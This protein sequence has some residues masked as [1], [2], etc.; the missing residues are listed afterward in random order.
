MA[1]QPSLSAKPIGISPSFFIFA[2]SVLSSS[3]VAGTW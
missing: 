1:G 2:L 3:K